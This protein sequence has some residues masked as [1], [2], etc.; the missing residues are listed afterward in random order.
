MFFI[1]EFAVFDWVTPRNLTVLHFERRFITLFSKVQQILVF[2]IHCNSLRRFRMSLEVLQSLCDFLKNSAADSFQ[3]S[4]PFHS[5]GSLLFFDSPWVP[6][7]VSHRQT[8]SSTQINYRWFDRSLSR[9]YCFFNPLLILKEFYT[10]AC[11]FLKKS[12]DPSKSLK[13]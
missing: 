1:T 9:N 10:E 11:R 13:S 12:G 4:S 5:P 3:R 8:S 2:L 7:S 6:N